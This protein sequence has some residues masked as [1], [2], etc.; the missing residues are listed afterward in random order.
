MRHRSNP[1]TR[2]T[3]KGLQV[4]DVDQTTVDLWNLP[5]YPQPPA[6]LALHGLCR[7]KPVEWWIP[8]HGHQS[9]RKAFD[10]CAAC[11]VQAECL[12]YALADPRLYGMWGGKTAVQRKMMR[13]RNKP[14][15][16][17]TQAGWRFHINHQEP[18]CTA[19][20]AAHAPY[21]AERCGTLAG[22]TAHGRNH[23][24]TCEP[25]RAAYKQW[26]RLRRA[27]AA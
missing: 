10:L 20:V 22:Y 15:E 18:P 5:D 8:E 19:C 23:E 26:K 2:H 3:S 13:A 12:N 6:T 25:C 24:P 1:T 27:G 21:A 11:P 17:G 16:C 9:P 4:T 7:G 14:V